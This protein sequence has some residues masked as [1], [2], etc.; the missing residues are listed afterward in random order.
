MLDTHL[1]KSINRKHLAVR[2]ASSF[3][4]NGTSFVGVPSRSC[5]C[6]TGTLQMQSFLKNKFAS[7]S[8]DYLPLV[9][10]VVEA[11]VYSHRE[12]VL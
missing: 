5:I 3:L 11:L 6:Q 9:L 7:H 4:N 1:R 10:L 8:C 2:I 12:V